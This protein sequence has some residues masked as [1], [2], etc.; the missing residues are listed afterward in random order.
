MIQKIEP[1]VF[2]GK[3]DKRYGSTMKTID[4]FIFLNLS[5]TG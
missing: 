3:G 5:K 2:D 4:S 1:M